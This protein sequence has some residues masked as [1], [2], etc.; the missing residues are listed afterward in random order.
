MPTRIEITD[1]AKLAIIEQWEYYDAKEVA[2]LSESWDLAV[3]HAIESL[4]EASAR[5]ASYPL[6][7]KAVAGLRWIPVKGFP[8][9]LFYVFEPI[10]S[11]LTVVHLL[12]DKRD[13]ADLLE[14]TM[15]DY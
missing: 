6:A 13:I 14:L 12:H 3:G 2:G 5:G 10:D 9:R 7:S 11:L 15:R 4:R 1:T 8:F